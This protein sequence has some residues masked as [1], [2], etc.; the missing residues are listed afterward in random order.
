[1][2]LVDDRKAESALPT[3]SVTLGT[4][5]FPVTAIIFVSPQQRVRLR[6]LIGRIEPPRQNLVILKLVG[7]HLIVVRQPAQAQLQDMVGTVA[8]KAAA[9]IGLFSKV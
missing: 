5:F 9:S 3:S 7:L 1:V 8:C 6:G 4:N 2:H